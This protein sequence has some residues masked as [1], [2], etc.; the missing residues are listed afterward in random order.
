MTRLKYPLLATA[1][2]A[3]FAEPA[4][5]HT[6]TG[7]GFALKDGF[8]HPLFGLDHLLAMVAVGLL[9]WRL[10]GR[11]LWLLPV[12]FVGVMT[13]GAVMSYSGFG[14]SGVEVAILAS[15]V[16][17]GLALALDARPSVWLA[18][19]VIAAFALAHGH[20][21]GAEVPDQASF[22]VYVAGFFAATALLHA[23][24]VGAGVLLARHA[25]LVRALGALIALAGVGLATA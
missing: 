22:P 13:A 15:V 7:S 10:G 14:M 9:A 18:L 16:V 19:P 12:T 11:A 4:L 23:A 5:A 8:V 24:G 3:S 21:H 2:V 6:G 25:V 1:L 20:A 17:L